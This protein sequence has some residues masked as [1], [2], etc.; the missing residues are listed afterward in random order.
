MDLQ[1]RREARTLYLHMK[2]FEGYISRICALEINNS[3]TLIPEH[4]CQ[5]FEPGMTDSAKLI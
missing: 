4:D 5:E 3:R 1:L 2:Y